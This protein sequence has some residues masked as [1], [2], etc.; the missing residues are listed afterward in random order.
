MQIGPAMACVIFAVAC[1]GGRVTDVTPTPLAMG[2]KTPPKVGT[3]GLGTLYARV[4]SHQFLHNER[5][6]EEVLVRLRPLACR[7]AA[8]C[9]AE[10]E[11]V[12]RLEPMPMGEVAAMLLTWPSTAVQEVGVEMAC[13][14]CA[15]SGMECPCHEHSCTAEDI[16][17]LST[18]GRADVECGV[19]V[20][21]RRRQPWPR[22]P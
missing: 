20:V 22:R 16:V 7:D 17:P 11:R 6:Y 9:D 4:K 3:S 14:I 21:G 5:A 15:S 8:A 10:L 1:E 13:A 2:V 12:R 18:M 19:T